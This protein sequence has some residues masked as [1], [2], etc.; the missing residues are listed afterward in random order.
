[1]RGSSVG[2]GIATGCALDGV[3]GPVWLRIFTSPYR[4]DPLVSNGYL[5]LFP[6]G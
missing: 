3:G 4:P 2:T 6:R 1:M 5:G